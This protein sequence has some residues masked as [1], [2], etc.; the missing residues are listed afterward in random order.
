MP[1]LGYNSSACC[2][3]QQV[4]TV[5]NCHK[6]P[7]LRYCPDPTSTC[8][9]YNSYKYFSRKIPQT[10]GIFSKEQ[11]LLKTRRSSNFLI[12]LIQLLLKFIYKNKSNSAEE[13]ET[14][15]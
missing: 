9:S 4:K 5:K 10:N 11:I 7:G 2:N 15:L 6:E 3:S 14:K 13:H 12:S 1:H 8:E